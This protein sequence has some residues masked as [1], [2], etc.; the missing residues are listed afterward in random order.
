MPYLDASSRGGGMSINI[1]EAFLHNAE[2][3]SPQRR[4][5]PI[6][7]GVYPERANKT[8]AIDKTIDIL[9]QTMDQTLSAQCRWVHQIAE[10]PQFL[11]RFL[12]GSLQAIKV[13]IRIPREDLLI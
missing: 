13:L 3:G 10:R 7:L 11:H 9:L 12:K 6:D 2:Y 5:K 1:G 4:G 8:G